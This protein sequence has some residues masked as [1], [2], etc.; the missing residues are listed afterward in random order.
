MGRGRGT[1]SGQRCSRTSG[2]AFPGGVPAARGIRTQ[3]PEDDGYDTRV[4]HQ[5]FTLDPADAPG[6]EHR[7]QE[8]RQSSMLPSEEAVT[9]LRV[10]YLLAS[11]A[12]WW[13]PNG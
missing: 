7:F 13:D 10:L 1:T 8:G 9:A 4:A 2:P 12:A 6:P 11:S 3:M 5:P